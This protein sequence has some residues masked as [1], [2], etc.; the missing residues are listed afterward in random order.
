FG[1]SR[2]V[3]VLGNA[4][5]DVTDL[6]N[7]SGMARTPTYFGAATLYGD[8]RSLVEDRRTTTFYPPWRLAAIRKT[9]DTARDTDQTVARANLRRQVEQALAMV[10]GGGNVITGTDAPIADMA[11]SIHLNLRAMV[12]YGF[13]PHQALVTATSAAADHLNEP[14]G[15]IAPGAYA[16]I[17]IVDG[18]PLTNINDAAAV[19]RVLTAGVEHTVD[20]LLEQFAS[21]GTTRSATRSV[22]REPVPEPKENKRF[23]WHGLAYVEGAR[24]A[25]CAG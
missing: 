6:F 25:C 16:D 13:T 4:Y 14:L 21:T 12:T 15:R 23:W 19:D 1:F 7:A 3:T 10:R 2:T 17:T 11:V 9:A 5:A 8:D 22:V 20:D 24:H 18:D